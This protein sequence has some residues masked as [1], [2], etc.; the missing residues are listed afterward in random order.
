M[1]EVLWYLFKY[2]SEPCGFAKTDPASLLARVC[3]GKSI[4]REARYEQKESLGEAFCE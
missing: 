4:G 1:Q 3:L 2:N